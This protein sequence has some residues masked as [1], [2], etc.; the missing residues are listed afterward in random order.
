MR[1]PL[2]AEALDQGFRRDDVAKPHD[3]RKHLGESAGVDDARPLIEAHQGRQRAAHIAVFAVVIVLD[4][5]GIGSG[6]PI[7]QFKP[8][9]QRHGHAGRILPGRR[10]EGGAG[11]FGFLQATGDDEALVI[12]RHGYHA[13]AAQGEDAARGG[14]SRLLEP[15]FVA[16]FQDG[17]ADEIEGIE[18]ACGDD[19]L[20]LVTA[21]APPFEQMPGDRLAE[22]HPAEAVIVFEQR[23]R[24]IAPEAAQEPA[25]IVMR[26]I[27]PVDEAGTERPRRF[28]LQARARGQRLR[29]LYRRGC[30]QLLGQF[31][32]DAGAG[33][34]PCFEI[35]LAQQLLIGFDHG[36]A[37]DAQFFRQ[38]PGRWQFGLR[39]Q[40]AAQHQRAHL[41]GD[42]RLDRLAV[43]A[44]DADLA[45]GGS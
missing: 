2:G 27:F 11:V 16:G 23:H 24:R 36:G 14:V 17:A 12:D 39:L 20:I 8:P 1:K 7:Q 22:R 19:H 32:R 30:Q 33:T 40:A 10:H 43:I 45:G 41:P 25:P 4:D 28:A 5:D 18:A 15:H 9:P 3:R 44:V 13:H 34:G 6:C 38:R 35:A 31:R 42:L 26:K 29:R 37:G 21:Q